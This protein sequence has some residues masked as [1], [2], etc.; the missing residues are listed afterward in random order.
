[1]SNNDVNRLILRYFGKFNIETTKDIAKDITKDIAKDKTFVRDI[2]IDK[3]VQL[4]G[5]YILVKY[6]KV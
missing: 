4:F 3:I 6:K 1:M 5:K 2:P